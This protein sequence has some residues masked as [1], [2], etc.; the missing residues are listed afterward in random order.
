MG[1]SGYVIASYI[2]QMQVMLQIVKCEMRKIA[3]L[4]SP[5]K[6]WVQFLLSVVQSQ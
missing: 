5:Q 2:L 3:D 6:F 1:R 4:F